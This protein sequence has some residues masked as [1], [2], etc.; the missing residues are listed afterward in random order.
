[1]S[2]VGDNKTSIPKTPANTQGK[3]RVDFVKSDFEAIIQLKGNDVFHEKAVKCPCHVEKDGAALSS[4][5]NC[6][7]SGWVFINK[8]E[9]RMV[10]T[11]MNIETKFKE[12]SEE[13]LGRV[14]VTSRDCD[15]LSFMDRITVIDAEVVTS[16]LLYP[17]LVDDKMR[18]K[19]IYSVKRVQEIFAYQG[20]DSPLRLL[21]EGAA[22]DYTIKNN[23]LV[24]DD[25]FKDW[26]N[27]SISVRYVHAPQFNIMD[28][29][30]ETMVTTIR[31]R[32]NGGVDKDVLMPISAVARRTHYVLDELNY[33]GTYLF[34]NSYDPGCETGV[35]NPSTCEPVVIL[36][37]DGEQLTVINPGQEYQLE[38]SQILQAVSGG[39][40]QF[41]QFLHPGEDYIIP[42][43]EDVSI[44]SD[45]NPVTTIAPG[46]SFDIPLHSVFK[47]DMSLIESVEYD[48]DTIVAD[49]EI[50]RALQ[51]G[52]DELVSSILAEGEYLIP[53]NKFYDNVGTL[54]GGGTN[55]KQIHITADFDV[56][57]ITEDATK[58]TITVPG[59][60]TPSGINYNNLAPDIEEQFRTGDPYWHL[61]NGTFDPT[62]NANPLHTA[63]IDPN[64]VQSD[65]RVTPA[66]GTLGTDS[67][68][69]TLLVDD[70]AFGNK[71]RFTDDQ[72][73][74]SNATVGSDIWAHVNWADHNWVTSGSTRGYVIDHYYGIGMMVDYITDTGTG[75]YGLDSTNGQSWET[76]ID[77]VHLNFANGPYTAGNSGWM[78]GSFDM[79]LKLPFGVN[80]QVGSVSGNWWT[81]NFIRGNYQGTGSSRYQVLT[82]TTDK[83]L[84]TSC[85]CIWD[86]S[87]TIIADS[88][89][90]ATTTGFNHRITGVH[91]IRIDRR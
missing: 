90:K 84:N 4:C 20:T 54:I 76:W 14:H 30:R 21:I 28:L 89:S 52:G 81:Y 72:G 26:E 41:I 45:G 17:K 27:L 77:Y 83:S 40:N 53:V 33:D 39:P 57:D 74:P 91:P 58:V 47:S 48:T 18:C 75:K 50:K 38:E 63:T 85:V 55:L 19:T 71:Y 88:L 87:R 1:M 62:F 5:R 73:N 65:I 82:G 13:K 64:A 10:L 8:M 32:D 68:A 24:L 42:V 29:Q 51:A 11:G 46:G 59:P 86:S 80:S 15:E 78:I 31:D 44:L 70:N 16:Q 56:S 22:N 23:V 25:E 43:A 36:R 2:G 3:A 60:G 35:A 69:P 67:I 61:N 66:S 79:Y 6:G 12:W 9:T 37:S 34:D 49:T 7:G